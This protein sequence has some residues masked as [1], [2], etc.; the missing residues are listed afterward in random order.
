LEGTDCHHYNFSIC[1]ARQW[2]PLRWGIRTWD[3]GHDRK[4]GKVASSRSHDLELGIVAFIG[5]GTIALE[6]V[7]LCHNIKFRRSILSSGSLSPGL[8]VFAKF[9]WLRALEY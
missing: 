2:A 7:L 6:A 1:L 3:H 5:L 8:R 9:T 4:F